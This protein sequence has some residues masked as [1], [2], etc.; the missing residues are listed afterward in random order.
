[1]MRKDVG[2][3]EA[4]IMSLAPR[5]AAELMKVSR[6]LAFDGPSLN[7]DGRRRIGPTQGRILTFLLSRS[8]DHITLSSLAEG[9]ALSHAT[10]S[11]AVRA[12]KARG[13]VRKARSKDDAR[14][15]F[16]SLS[17]AG[18][19]KAERA[20]AGSH[21]LNTVIERLT[22]REQELVFHTLKNIQQAMNHGEKKP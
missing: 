14:V 15:V 7:K 1:M 8:P 16:L 21:H 19:R 20:L 18:R 10:A 6:T 11:E 13:F 2:V 17:A 12:L 22:S 5:V 3:I 9:A 4:E